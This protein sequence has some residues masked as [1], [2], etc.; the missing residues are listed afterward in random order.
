MTDETRVKIGNAFRGKKH[1]EETKKRISGSRIA[2]I[3]ANPHMAPYKINHY[4]KGPSYPERYWK[5]ILDGAGLTY[6]EQHQVGLYSLD[7]AFPEIM[8]DLEIDGSQH[9]SDERIVDSDLRRTK[10]LEDL[11]WKTIRVFW[12]DFKAL[13]E[14]GRK[15]YVN[16]ILTILTIHR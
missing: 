7:F 14:Q 4:S 15:D 2:F 11:G 9:K 8:V 3:E 1:T 13:P 6:I 16:E 10:Y 12:P 5:E